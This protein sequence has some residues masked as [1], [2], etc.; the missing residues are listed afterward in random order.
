MASSEHAGWNIGS[1][2]ILCEFLEAA[3]HHILYTRDV[4]P[5]ELFQRGRLY[6]VPIQKSRHP[7]LNEYIS[8]AVFSIHKWMVKGGLHTVVLLIVDEKHTPVERFV[9][10]F[11]LARAQEEAAGLPLDQI[12]RT[13]SAFI[14]KISLTHAVVKPLPIGCRFQILVHSL[15]TAPSESASVGEEPVWAEQAPSDRPNVAHPTVV[16]DSPVIVP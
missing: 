9:F 13:L 15:G 2:E 11:Q 10:R 6:N 14:S 12:E 8:S 1:K 4:Y 16:I 5:Q 7:D 3:F